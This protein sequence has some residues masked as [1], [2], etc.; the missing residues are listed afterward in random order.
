VTFVF[1][2]HTQLGFF[3]LMNNEAAMGKDVRS[4]PQ[5]WEIYDQWIGSGAA[6][7]MEEPTGIEQKLRNRT[8]LHTASP[9]VWADAYL[10]AFAEAAGLTLVTFDRSLAA[11]VKGA[12][13]LG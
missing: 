13:V 6:I 1:C 5:C 4:Q 9:K 2:R 10:A 12:V 8:G 7:F 11:K 3:R